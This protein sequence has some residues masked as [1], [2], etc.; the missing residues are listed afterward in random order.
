VDLE[1]GALDGPHLKKVLNDPALH[2][3]MPSEK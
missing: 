3:R 2:C 1:S